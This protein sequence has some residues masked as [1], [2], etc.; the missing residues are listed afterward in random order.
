MQISFTSNALKKMFELTN[1]KATFEEFNFGEPGR[2]EWFSSRDVDLRPLKLDK[3]NRLRALV[4]KTTKVRGNKTV[5]H[6]ID[7]WISIVKGETK[8]GPGEIIPRTMKQFA[9]L[10]IEFLRPTP[11]RHLYNRDEDGVWWC[12]YANT[13]TYHPPQR[14]HYGRSPASC[15]LHLVYEEFGSPRESTIHFGE[16]DLGAESVRTILNRKG[17]YIETPE[18]RS[19]YEEDV[20]RFNM[21]ATRIGLQM[22]A[23]GVADDDLDGNNKSDRGYWWRSVKNIR[24]DRADEATRV[25][26][27]VFQ[28][29]DEDDRR[30]RRR[31]V[32]LA[33]TFWSSTMPQRDATVYDD[34]DEDDRQASMTDEEIEASLQ[35][36]E[37][38]IH[39]YCATYDLKRHMRLRVHIRNLTEYEYD[40][41]L[42]ERLV[43]PADVIDLVT[44]LIQQKGGFRDI[45]GKKGGGAVILCAGSPGTGKTLTAE[46]YAE[47]MRRPLYNV[48]ASQL[49]LGP[50]ELEEAL[51]KTFAR[52]ARWG[53]ILLIDEADVYVA[54]R[55]NNLEQNA[56]VGVFLRVLEYYQGIL[57]MTTN[58]SDLVD[59]A[60]ASRCIARIDYLVPLPQDQKRI[61]RILAETSGA[62]ISDETI[63]QIV[64]AHPKLSGRDV[65][66]LLKLSM[67]MARAKKQ[68]IS[69]EMIELARR[70]KPTGERE[71]GEVE[72]RAAGVLRLEA[73]AERRAR[74]FE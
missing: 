53:A 57:F 9:S 7:M 11:R 69:L 60:I 17:Y 16:R 37:V 51:L 28:E 46:V 34:E 21:Y 15:S 32:K 43:L 45:I 8:K 56:I 62:D 48:Q 44:M 64:Q 33:L 29:E 68:P 65:K 38:P 55:G 12:Y 49:G 27:D 58:R 14:D 40:T 5:L 39:P 24:L 73:N 6:D 52:A 35:N 66:N 10:L 25:V 3:I 22:T 63:D 31:D 20:K 2:W 72:Q 18:L 23:V 47:V 54:A 61:W 50:E 70:F 36:I 41:S 67:L 71:D 59:D 74:T 19:F 13:V 4:E 1:D 26:I 30:S 42:G